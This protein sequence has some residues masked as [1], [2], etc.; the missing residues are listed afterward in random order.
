MK[1]TFYSL[2][3]L[4]TDFHYGN[5]RSKFSQ[6]LHF[7]IVWQWYNLLILNRISISYLNALLPLRVITRTISRSFVLFQLFWNNFRVIRISHDYFNLLFIIWIKWLW[8]MD[9]S[10]LN[11]IEFI[12]W[13]YHYVLLPSLCEHQI[14]K[15]L[16][17]TTWPKA[18]P[19]RSPAEIVS[20][21]ITR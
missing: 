3:L 18:H 6:V 2:A 5:Y 9:V 19:L 12:S 15:I 13:L 1:T 4:I 17:R 14:W 21:K 7:C 10:S 16:H 8:A 11:L 20:R